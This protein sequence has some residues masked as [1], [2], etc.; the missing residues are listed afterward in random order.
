M[1]LSVIISMINIYSYLSETQVLTISL[2]LDLF[3]RLQAP[4]TNDSWLFFLSQFF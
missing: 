2:V 1:L 4:L 3:Q